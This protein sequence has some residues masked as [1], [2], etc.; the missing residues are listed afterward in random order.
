MTFSG[1]VTHCQSQ[2]ALASVDA[3]DDGVI[4]WLFQRRFLLKKDLFQHSDARRRAARDLFQHSD[5]RRRAAR[6]LFRHSDAR[7][8]VARDLFRQENVSK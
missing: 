4:Y 1:R 8:R 5:A 6:D 3:L 7:R 2:D